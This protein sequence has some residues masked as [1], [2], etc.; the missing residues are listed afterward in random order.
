MLTP[1]QEHQISTLNPFQFSFPDLNPFE[2]VLVH[3]GVL[4]LLPIFIISSIGVKT[5]QRAYNFI[6]KN[7]TK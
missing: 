5:I 2:W 3:A 1:N 4:I 6:I 7:P